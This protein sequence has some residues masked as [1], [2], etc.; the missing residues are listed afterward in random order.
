MK[1]L[2]LFAAVLAATFTPLSARAE[3]RAEFHQVYPL[4]AG[5]RVA[6]RNINGSIQVAAWERN[7]VKVDAVK[8]GR[9][10]QDLDEARIVVDASAS[11]VDIRTKYPE[12]ENHQHAASVEYTITVP[13]G[14]SL[15]R[16]EAVNGNVTIEGVA[17]AVRVNS[18]NGKV[19]VRRA[20]G[21]VEASTVNGRVEAAFERLSSHRISL[22]TVNGG[23]LLALP[24]GRRCAPQGQHGSR[25]HFERFRPD[26]AARRLRTGQQPRYHHRLGGRGRETRHRQRR[27]QPHAPVSAPSSA[28]NRPATRRASYCAAARRPASP[29]RFRSSASW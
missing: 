20:E 5:G 4:E 18:V 24:Q 27:H 14:A 26:R 9:S 25:R 7:E 15:D 6:V 22:N 10:Q 3:V 1:R 2:V 19:D 21:D 29:S 23:I 16:I 12:H 11:S 8:S 17:G 28:R 13:R